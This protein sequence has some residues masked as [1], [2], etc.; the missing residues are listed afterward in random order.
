LKI[1]IIRSTLHR[2]SGQTVHIRELSRHLIRLGNEVSV[3]SHKIEDPDLSG[4]GVQLEFS[5]DG[6]P[7][8]RNLG[9]AA[10]CLCRIGEFDIVH[11]QYHPSIIAG[12][13]IHKFRNRPHV[14]TYHGFAPIRTWRNPFQKL[15]MADHRVGAFF[16]LRLGLD[17]IIAVSHFLKDELV[18][19]YRLSP[20][21]I[22]V[23]YNG[24]DLE[25]FNPRVD[26]RKVR[27]A[28]SLGERPLVAFIGRLAPYKGPQFLLQ[29]I[30]H[31]LKRVPDAKFMFIGSA[32]FDA[33]RISEVVQRTDIRRAVT[34]TGYVDDEV[35]P[36]FYASCDVF[37]YPS[38]WEGFGLTPA[39]AQAS[40]KP[41]VAFKTCA[42]PEVVEDGATGFLVPAGNSIALAEAIVKLLRDSELSRKMGQRARARVEQMFSWERAARQTVRVYKEALEVHEKHH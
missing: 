40:G 12:N 22:S 21:L 41:V 5:L 19:W 9:F 32:R 33:P 29:A 31:V 30:P 4:V 1:A 37:C 27:E 13:C 35:L 36:R 18:R 26:G 8:I 16:S 11:T 24:V 25:R 38:L 14:F 42:L 7:F 23:V 28:Y 15:K 10:A 3:F 17:R 6:I 39:E 20:E 34:F 2:G